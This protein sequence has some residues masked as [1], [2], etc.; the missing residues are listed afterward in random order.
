MRIVEEP[1]VVLFGAQ[2]HG[3]EERE[4]VFGSG[5]GEREGPSARADG[6][7]AA[8]ISFENEFVDGGP[9][10]FRP[11]VG[12]AVDVQFVPRH[13]AE[14]VN[15]V[16]A[17]HDEDAAFAQR[18]EFGGER[19]VSG[20]IELGVET[21]LHDRNIRIRVEVAQHRPGAVVEA[22][23]VVVFDE[24]FAGQIAHLLRKQRIPEGRILHCIEFGREAPE[25]VDGARLRHS[26]HPGPAGFPMGRHAH[27]APGTRNPCRHF[28]ESPHEV[29]FLDG[30]HRTSVSEEE[31]RH[32][33]R[34]GQAAGKPFE[35]GQCSQQ[36]DNRE[37]L[38]EPV[39]THGLKF[40]N[41]ASSAPFFTQFGPPPQPHPLRPF[42]RRITL[43]PSAALQRLPHHRRGRHRSPRG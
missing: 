43:T 15:D 13:Q 26:G 19:K 40:S 21:E 41:P 7:Q 18:A 4:V 14:V 39:S 1:H 17:A 16:A 6:G 9:G 22:P 23:C 12:I 33:R 38:Q 31:H 27:D 2:A 25:I 8:R 20:G 10:L 24:G 29:I 36:G 35:P 30:V 42:H 37:R 5:D 34:V 3:V 32:G 11:A 28:P